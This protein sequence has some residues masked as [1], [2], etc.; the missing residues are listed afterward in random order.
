MSAVQQLLEKIFTPFAD[1][2]SVLIKLQ[3]VSIFNRNIDEELG[4]LFSFIA[5]EV[6]SIT[7]FYQINVWYL[8]SMSH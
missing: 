7:Y 2:K 8:N 6:A 4:S 1:K 3:N 5:S